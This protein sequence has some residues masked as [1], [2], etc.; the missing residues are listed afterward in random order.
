[1]ISFLGWWKSSHRVQVQSSHL[2]CT[3]TS[4][5][6]I[7]G[8]TW[9]MVLIVTPGVE[10]ECLAWLDLYWEIVF[11]LG[12]TWF[13][14]IVLREYTMYALLSK[15]KIFTCASPMVNLHR[16]CILYH[17]SF[18]VWKCSMKWGRCHT[19][20]WCTDVKQPWKHFTSCSSC[21]SG[22]YFIPIKWCHLIKKIISIGDGNSTQILS[23]LWNDTWSIHEGCHDAI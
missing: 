1:M 3:S 2:E 13:V 23:Q 4:S 11:T 16:H 14:L 9:S 15:L 10:L 6:L 18:F 12:Q 17:S 19:C 22:Y 8:D 20:S 5:C 21:N 7:S